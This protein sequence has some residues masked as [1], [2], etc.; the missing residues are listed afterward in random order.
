MAGI[1]DDLDTQLFS[2][3]QPIFPQHNYSTIFQVIRAVRFRVG[4]QSNAATLLPQCIEMLLDTD[5]ME[6]LT[7]G[8]VGNNIV[9]PKYGPAV[10]VG[11]LG[12][13]LR[14]QGQVPFPMAMAVSQPHIFQWQGLSFQ[15]HQDSFIT[16]PNPDI[17]QPTTMPSASLAQPVPMIANVAVMQKKPPNYREPPKFQR[18]SDE[19]GNESDS[20]NSSSDDDKSIDN[21]RN[22]HVN[23]DDGNSGTEQSN[24]K[25]SSSSSNSESVRNS[26]QQ[27]NA[28]D[29]TLGSELGDDFF[30]PDSQ[31]DIFI[32]GEKPGND[33]VIIESNNTKKPDPLKIN[34]NQLHMAE[35]GLVN[36]TNNHFNTVSCNTEVHL[37][38]PAATT[39]NPIL[40]NLLGSVQHG[41]VSLSSHIAENLQPGMSSIY[42]KNNDPVTDALEQVVCFYN[43]Y[44]CSSE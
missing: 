39:V 33:V 1:A 42:T 12:L 6:N 31:D 8:Q 41:A 7:T 27:Q 19:S 17:F 22:G 15:P 13:G 28:S 3:I 30:L 4:D 20:H 25:D 44:C 9:V 21:E 37:T 18:W 14:P 10:P 2:Q 32:V 26:F 24:D 34:G 38:Q 40:S 43:F 11:G 29:I 16:V 5:S 36:N 35:N 23:S